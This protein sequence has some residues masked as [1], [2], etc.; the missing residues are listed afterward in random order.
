M[1]RRVLSLVLSA[2]LALP[3]LAREASAAGCPSADAV[4]REIVEELNAVRAE[5]RYCGP[6]RS[7][8]AKPLQWNRK[9][10]EAAAKHAGEMSRSDRLSHESADGRTAGDRITQAGYA[11]RAYGE[12]I[13]LGQQTVKEV[14][15]SWLD[16]AEHC[17]NIMD[18]DFAEIGVACSASAGG[19]PYWVMVLAAPLSNPGR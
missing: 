9:L 3:V 14:V 18:A 7:G 19:A 13:A 5:P 10:F 15:R 1:T 11:W 16:S 2:G 6:K 17:S 12:N 8:P 4:R